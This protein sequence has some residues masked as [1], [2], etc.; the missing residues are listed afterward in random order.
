MRVRPL[1]GSLS[2]LAL[3]GCA[4]TIGVQ[5]AGPGVWAVSEM[6]APVLGGGPAAQDA[7][8]REANGFCAQQGLVFVPVR[9]GPGGD[10]YSHYGP[11]A[12]SGT[13]R[14]LAANDPAVARMRAGAS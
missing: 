4:A 14:C 11:L 2:V 3:A 8:L 5:P 10:P 9:M 6:R 7:A 12:F 1:A 13:F